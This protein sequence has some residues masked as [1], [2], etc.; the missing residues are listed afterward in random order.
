VEILALIFDFFKVKTIHTSQL[1]V[2]WETLM[3]KF[4]FYGLRSFVFELET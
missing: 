2:R 1:F 3:P 4:S